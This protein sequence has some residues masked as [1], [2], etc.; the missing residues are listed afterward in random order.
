MSL[1]RRYWMAALAVGA[2]AAVVV[3]VPTVL[4]PNPLFARPVPPRPIDYAVWLASA[5]LVGL[6]V[7][8]YVPGAARVP[9][10]APEASPAGARLTAGGV[11]SFFAV[12]CPT[13]NKVVV[14]L[15]GSSGALSIF[16]PLQPLLGALSLALLGVTLWTRLRAL[17]ASG[18]ACPTGIAPRLH[19]TQPRA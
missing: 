9:S 2:T 1:G 15:L 6:L 16:A 11:L 14:L 5:A 7:A 13:C 10:P 12:G 19:S 17:G 8:T 4:I 3:G 18:A